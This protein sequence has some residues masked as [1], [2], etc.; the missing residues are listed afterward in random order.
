MQV[1]IT[2]V[3]S[4]AAV[5]SLAKES[6]H[7]ILRE[8]P[9]RSWRR[10]CDYML[11]DEVPD[12]CKV[13]MI[14]LKT[15]LQEG[16]YGLEQLRRSLPL[17]KYLLSVCEVELQ[18]SWPSQ[19]TYAL[20]AE[21]RADRIDK[22]PVRARTPVETEHYEGIKVTVGVGTRFKFAALAAVAAS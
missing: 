15:T 9:G 13:T 18:R 6:Q 7:P 8:S 21:K 4:T 1:Q 19:F 17:A 3:P 12:G 22:Q 2:Q 11:L 5:V 10:I 20:I 14:E 16:T